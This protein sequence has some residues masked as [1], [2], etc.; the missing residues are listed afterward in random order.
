MPAGSLTLRPADLFTA[1]GA[2][3][4]AGGLRIPG[5]PVATPGTSSSALTAAAA[6][7]G[8]GVPIGA[9]A[10]AAAAIFAVS[11]LLVLHRKRRRGGLGSLSDLKSSV[12]SSL[13]RIPPALGRLRALSGRR[14]GREYLSR[15]DDCEGGEPKRLTAVDEDKKEAAEDAEGGSRL[16]GGKKA[17]GGLLGKKGPTVIVAERVV[18]RACGSSKL[19]AAESGAAKPKPDVVFRSEKL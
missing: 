10:G 3:V 17:R 1:D 11:G 19:A 16:L 13:G 9:I 8:G 7:D 12:R 14:A 6:N 4:P 15:L 5:G 2:L 18:P